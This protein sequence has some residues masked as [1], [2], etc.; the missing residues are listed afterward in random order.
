[1]WNETF[2]IPVESMA[3]EV[4][5]TCLDEDLMTNDLVGQTAVTM[6]TLCTGAVRKWIP[7]FYKSQVSAELLVDT[8]Y[9][10]PYEEDWPVFEEQ[11]NHN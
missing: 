4:K 11:T 8:I 6:S 5:L 2:N 9:T 7:L 10:P 1:M 3:E